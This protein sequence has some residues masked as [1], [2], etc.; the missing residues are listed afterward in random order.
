MAKLSAKAKVGL[1]VIVGSVLLVLMTF[2]VGKYEFGKKEGYTLQADF[3][4]VAGLDIKSSVRMAGVKIGLVDKVELEDS[5][6][7]VTLRINPEVKIQRG[8]EAMIKTMGLLG[9]KYVEFVPAKKGRSLKPSTVGAAYYQDGERVEATV[10]PSDVDK[11]INQLSSISDDIKQVTASLSQVFG[12]E[13]GARSMED[14]LNDLRQTTANIKD[15]SNTLRSNGSEMVM[16]LNNLVASLNGVVGENRDSIKV[17]MENIKDFSS[18]LQSDGGEMVMRLNELVASLN[19]VVDENRGNLKVT[20]ENIK[21]ASKSAELALTSIDNAAR[22]IDRGEGTIGKLVNDESMYNNID[23]AA[24]GVSDYTSRIERMKTIVGFREEYMFSK[25]KGYVTLE[26]KPRW[27]QYYIFEVT[28]DPYGYYKQTRTSFIPGSTVVTE[29]Y[30]DKFKFSLEFAK[31]W[32]NLALRF[33]LI[34]STGGVGADYFAYDDRIK[35]SVEAWNFNDTNPEP[36]NEHAHVKATAGLRLGKAAFV[37]AG[38]D[39]ILNSRRASPFVGLGLRFDD[40]DLKYLMG[41]API[42]K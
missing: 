13:R 22:K 36:G 42:P 8:T 39:N 21:E 2:A 31:R 20:M 4:S 1:L 37:E 9:E 3:D 40:E 6:A 32:S 26:F 23:S 17:T 35:F 33:G 18:T 15:F 12:T 19:G 34:E 27:D 25:S 41:S 38:Y 16:S 10:S 5:R 28:S 24:K 11:L 29:T 7:K 14:M 30:E